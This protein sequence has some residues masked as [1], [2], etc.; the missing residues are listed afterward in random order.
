MLFRSHDLESMRA[1]KGRLTHEQLL[2][3]QTELF[4]AVNSGALVVTYPGPLL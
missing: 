3:I 2:D 1:L 4:P